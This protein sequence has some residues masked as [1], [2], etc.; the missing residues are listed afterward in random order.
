MP[1]V[2]APAKPKGF[3]LAGG[4]A[5]LVLVG[6]AA[7]GA[8]AGPW[9]SLADIRVERIASGLS[10]PLYVTAPRDDD[11]LFVVEQHTGRIRILDR[12]T[13][14]AAAAPFLDVDGL[15]TGGEQGLLGLA[16]HPDYAS[17]GFF[18]VNL[19]ASDGDTIIRRYRVSAQ[20][21]DQADPQSATTIMT[22]DQPF[23]NHNGGW[24]GFGPNDGYLYI[25]SGDGGSGHDP[26]NNAQDLTDNRLGKIL[27]I[28][29]DG[30]DFPADPGRNYAIPAGNPF[31]GSDGDDEIWAYGL[32]NP[33][34][35]SFDRMTG[36][37]F[38]ADV[39]QSSREEINFQDAASPGG[40]NYG[41]RLREGGIATP[42]GGVG[43]AR[44]P[45]SVD[46]VHDYGRSLGGSVTGGYV[47]RGPSADLAGLYFFGDFVSGRAWTGQFERDD[48]FVV[49]E[50]TQLLEPDAGAIDNIASF[51]EDAAGNLYIVDLD[52]E[53]FRI[54]APPAPTLRASPLG[55]GTLLAG[56]V[57]AEGLARGPAFQLFDASGAL[58][59][60]RFSL[61]PDFLTEAGFVVGNLDADAAQE[62]VVGAREIGGLARGPALQIFAPDG[63]VE[64]TRFVLNP[65]FS[66]VTFSALD[67]G[68]PGILVCGTEIGGLARGPAFQLFDGG[69]TLVRSRFALNRDFRENA[70]LGVDFDGLAG[71]EILV[72]GREWR[73]RAR[74]P[75]VQLFGADGSVRFTRFVLNPD[76]REVHVAV[77]SLGSGRLAVAGRESGGLARGPAFQIFD[78]GGNLLRTRFALNPD[79]T[80]VQMLAAN[81]DGVGED[82]IVV[83]G[84]EAGGLA[85]G[86]AFQ[87][88]AADGTLRR[89]RFVLNAGFTEVAFA[90]VD[91]DG[92][93]AQ[94]I[95]ALGR[96]SAGASRGPAF[97]LF[98]GGGA[99][100]LTRFVLNAD[101]TRQVFFPVPQPDGTTAIG[102]AGVE[103]QGLARGPAFQIWGSD[104]TLSLTRFVLNPDF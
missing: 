64:A 103:R 102:T 41:W 9:S 1:G 99:L 74:G 25:A 62:V 71:D 79:F 80:Q 86:P 28:D 104:G 17:N 65:D 94:E 69:G 60:T 18:Y 47:Y 49:R 7:P 59:L 70:C 22:Y 57:E 19:T 8:W 23:A 68:S 11:R 78:D 53:V 77:A 2:E 97:Q 31:V 58:L 30:D 14:Q 51:G 56:S 12:L 32:R 5:C 43:G 50:V 96:E 98:D 29:V 16:F 61:N 54:T 63:S 39:G 72:S 35:P 13:G 21:P 15:A 55:T 90:A 40:E 6:G 75:A 101:F 66:R 87:I 76:F 45:G 81:T 73:G 85:R 10:R 26:Q 93:G 83:G 4:L 37:L 33:W 3:R 42:T 52:G 91:V 24:L 92:D 48:A 34:R 88:F 95:L 67:T 46:P 82:E 38:I 36:D 84:L 89:T 100:L 20:N 27:R 44:P